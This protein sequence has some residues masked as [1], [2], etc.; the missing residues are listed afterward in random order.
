MSLLEK[1]Y[2]KFHG[3]YEAINGGQ[4]HVGLADLT[5]GVAG[6]IDL[7]DKRAEIASGELFATVKQYYDSGYLLGAGSPSGSDTD[8]SEMGIVQ[9][10]AYSILNIVEESDQNG[11][12]QLL[13]LRNPWGA[14][15]WKGTWSDRDQHSWTSRMRQRLNYTASDQDDDDGT[16]WMSFQDFCRHYS[17]ISLCRMF[18][19][20][21][22][23][24]Q[25]H[26]AT[27]QAEWKGKTAGGCP[28]P[29]NENSKYNPQWLL[30]LTRP[31][32]VFIQLEQAKPGFAA[33]RI[34]HE[35]LA[36]IAIFLLKLKG[37]RLGSGIYGGM[38]ANSAPYIN[39]QMKTLDVTKLDVNSDGYTIA[40]TT[41]KKAKEAGLTLTVFS[42]APFDPSCLVKN[43]DSNT[44]EMMITR[45]YHNDE[46]PGKDGKCFE[47]VAR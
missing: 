45:M 37:K 9:G 38:V 6:K 27:M 15:E 24:G 1:A 30:K 40:C 25:W 22:N 35:D 19:T 11:T 7:E 21:Q 13:E 46:T 8:I 4:V 12:H 29:A 5:G 32:H 33:G 43:P 17:E 44:G 34:A 42:D 31:G 2:S 28:Q 39:A 18:Q 26:K 3:S 41:F 47:T 20:V 16:F 14:G 23:G 10:H 36:S